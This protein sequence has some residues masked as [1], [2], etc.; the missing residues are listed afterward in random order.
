MEVEIVF[1]SCGDVHRGDVG[2][3]VRESLGEHFFKTGEAAP[4]LNSHKC[5]ARRDN[6]PASRA[7][8]LP[9]SV[10]E[11]GDKSG[12]YLSVEESPRVSPPNGVILHR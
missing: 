8:G 9:S 3:G 10:Q 6:R 11:T 4:Q 5:L 7:D 2:A 12:R 1:G